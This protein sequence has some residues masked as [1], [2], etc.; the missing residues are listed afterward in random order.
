MCE[1][2]RELR[3]ARVP[4]LCA[5]AGNNESELLANMNSYDYDKSLRNGVEVVGKTRCV[6]AYPLHLHHLAPRSRRGP[7]TGHNKKRL[8]IC[9]NPDVYA[10]ACAPCA[11]QAGAGPARAGQVQQ[12]ER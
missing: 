1:P 7:T 4:S 2:G 11:R 6:Q 3:V 9:L 8:A 5:C 10:C 12:P